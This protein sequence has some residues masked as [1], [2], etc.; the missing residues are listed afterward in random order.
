MHLVQLLLPLRDN[1]GRP[2]PPAHFAAVRD[3]LTERFGGLTA[4]TRAPAEGVWAPADDAAPAR[5][6]VVVYEVMDAAIDRDGW[7]RY[8]A[9]L[10][11]RFAQDEL[12]VRAHAVERL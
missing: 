12:V 7:A 11:R 4:Y 8:R 10:E 3:A 9:E 6:D 5:D 1:D 2:F